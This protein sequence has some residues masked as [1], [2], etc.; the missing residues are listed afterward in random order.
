MS[1]D[2]A[3]ANE[4]IWRSFLDGGMM[5]DIVCVLVLSKGCV[6][7]LNSKESTGRRKK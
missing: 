5:I 7:S 2:Q 3:Q 6:G 4:T 1:R